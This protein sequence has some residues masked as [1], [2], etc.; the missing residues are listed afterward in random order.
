MK[1]YKTRDFN[2]ISFLMTKSFIKLKDTEKNLDNNKPTIYFEFTSESDDDIQSLI[3]S[4]QIGNELVEPNF[5]TYK[6]KE[7]RKII[8]NQISK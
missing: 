2:E 6:Q 8:H 7:A 3:E 5:F 4:F 1:T